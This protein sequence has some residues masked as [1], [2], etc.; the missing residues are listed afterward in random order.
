MQG[1]QI[2]VESGADETVV[3][4][5]GDLDLATETEI[6][7]P[8]VKAAESSPRVVID[9]TGLGFVDS[10]GLRAL[11]VGREQCEAAGGQLVLRNASPGLLRL[12][13]VA[14]LSGVLLVESSDS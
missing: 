13:E 5:V 12:V 8:L 6:R 10:S 7:G 14:G 11:L 3:R 9:A 4:V 1:L 2:E